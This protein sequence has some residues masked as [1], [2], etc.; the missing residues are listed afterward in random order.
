MKIKKIAAQCKA[1]GRAC[2]YDYTDGDGCISQWIGNGAAVWPVNG[3]PML[4]AEHLPALFDLTGKQ[5]EE[6]QIEQ[7]EAPEGIDFR[8]YSN[9]DILATE[10]RLRVIWNG[11]ELMMLTAKGVTYYIDTELLAPIWAEYERDTIQY[12][13]RRQKDGTPYFAVLGGLLLVGLV[14]P[15]VKMQT[16]AGEMAAL[17]AGTPANEE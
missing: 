9:D 6:M 3:V 12:C 7:H 15:V 13:L 2:L 17:A 14:W 5:L 4:E 8:D 16:M 1:T 11:C 10:A